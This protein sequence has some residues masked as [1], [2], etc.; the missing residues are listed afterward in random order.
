MAR[1][2]P[3]AAV[4]GVDLAPVPVDM[5]NLPSN[6]RFEVDDVNLGLE[7][8]YGQYDVV[9]ARLISSGIKSYRTMME[10]AEKCLKPGGVVI[11]IDH[12][13]MFCAEDQISR[14]PMAE[15]NENGSWLVRSAFGELTET[16]HIYM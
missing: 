6:C 12:D 4:V 11:F 9:H 16:Y 1:T 3:H 14:Q 8:F 7:H 2:Y 13:A 5:S 10:E 15:S